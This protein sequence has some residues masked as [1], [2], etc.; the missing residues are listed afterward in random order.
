[1]PTLKQIAAN[2]ANAKKSTGP[3]TEEGKTQSKLNAWRHGITSQVNVLAEPDRVAY[4]AFCEEMTASFHP[5]T[6]IERQLA[7]SISED[8]W[9]LNRTRAIEN[10]IFALG[11]FGDAGNFTTEIEDVHGALTAAR[12]FLENPEPFRLISLYVQRTSREIQR[13]LATLTQIQK[14]RE[15]QRLAELQDAAF[16]LE[17]CRAEGVAYDDLTSRAAT[18]PGQNGFV[19]SIPEI[20]LYIVRKRRLAGLQIVPKTRLKRAA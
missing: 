7:Q 14:E 9:R 3:R 11:H 10:N 20:D 4:K 6:P 18:T 1:M 2:Q 8:S 13:N 19:F 12:T 15:A 16:I 17:A 5:A